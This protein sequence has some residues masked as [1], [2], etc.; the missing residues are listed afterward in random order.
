MCAMLLLAMLFTS[1]FFGFH[2]AYGAAALFITATLLLGAALFQFAQEAW[3]AR[4][5]LM[6]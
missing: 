6:E 4:R 2:H 3:H 1:Q 5:E